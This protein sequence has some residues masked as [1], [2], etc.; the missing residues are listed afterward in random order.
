M[1]F[2]KTLN[3]KILGAKQE[4]DEHANGYASNGT[5]GQTNGQANGS[6]QPSK[7]LQKRLGGVLHTLFA[8][9]RSLFAKKQK[10]DEKKQNAASMGKILNL[11]R[12]V[13]GKRENNRLFNHFSELRHPRMTA[14]VL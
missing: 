5:N 1:L 10:K 4:A 3:R 13:L 6:L 8:G 2:E 12:Y 11:M 14:N 9:F 7:G